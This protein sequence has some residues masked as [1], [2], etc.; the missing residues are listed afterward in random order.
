MSKN[1]KTTCKIRLTHSGQIGAWNKKE[2]KLVLAG[3]MFFVLCPIV[4]IQLISPF[5][6][7]PFSYAIYTMKSA[8]YTIIYVIYTITLNNLSCTYWCNCEVKKAQLSP[9]FY[10][11]KWRNN[12]FKGFSCSIKFRREKFLDNPN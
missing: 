12:A 1:R 11:R 4:F 10:E 2:E 8:I 7:H 9:L 5:A 6:L 3:P